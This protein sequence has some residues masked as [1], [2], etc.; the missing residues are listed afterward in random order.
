MG[1]KYL[2]LGSTVKEASS[3]ELVSATSIAVRT[4]DGARQ[5][6]YVGRTSAHGTEK[7]RNKV[8]NH[9]VDGICKPTGH[10]IPR[11]MADS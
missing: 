3:A 6:T 7:N 8:Y 10:V 5:Y 4:P 2:R 1:S 11:T 9:T